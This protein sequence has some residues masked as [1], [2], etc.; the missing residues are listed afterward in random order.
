MKLSCRSNAVLQPAP[1]LKEALENAQCKFG[2]R[3]GKKI[4]QLR[5]NL[6]TPAVTTAEKSNAP[7]VGLP[8][9]DGFLSYVAFRA[10][11]GN[12][13]NANPNLAKQ[14]LW[15]WNIALRHQE[16][17]I[18]FE[19]PLRKIPLTGLNPLYDCSVGLPVDVNGDILIPVGAF[20]TSNSQQFKIYPEIVDSIP[21]RRRVS[22]PFGRPIGLK[23]KLNTGGGSTKALDNRLYFP[24][25]KS[26]VF[27][28]RGDKSGVER[29]LD[30]ALKQQIGLGKK[31]TL[32]YGQLASFEVRQCSD[33]KATWTRTLSGPIYS[34]D[35]LALIKDL[36][37]DRVFARREI[38][39][40]P[41]TRNQELFGCERFALIATIETY[42]A[43]CPPY[44]LREQRTQIVR[45][46]S[47][48]QER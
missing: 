31:T 11:L 18:D 13:L 40:I 37:Y 48:I 6:A 42:G 7:A 22:E 46:G 28:F 36:P 1:T 20:F 38:S 45:Y 47:I 8:T 9:L 12:V 2:D 25:T 35:R 4:Y 15:Q 43:Y 41:D 26:Y 10:A 24:L 39:E 29:L 32:G 21:L 30:F 27:F 3:T 17:W 34:N 23:S 5:L 14:L 33:V 19:L 16:M 44:W